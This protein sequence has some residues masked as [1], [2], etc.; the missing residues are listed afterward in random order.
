MHDIA[1]SHLLATGA[2]FDAAM[3]SLFRRQV[4]AIVSM[5]RLS[6]MHNRR[7]CGQV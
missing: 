3:H 7:C 1:R 5:K 6:I 4:R 2:D